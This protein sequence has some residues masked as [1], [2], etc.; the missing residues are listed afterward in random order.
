MSELNPNHPV[1]VETR[2]QWHKLAAILM[3]KM[4]RV[5]VEIFP[6]DVE[7]LGNNQKGIVIDCRGGKFV[8]RL[9]PMQ[10]G[11]RL[12]REEGGLPV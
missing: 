12:A 7:N 10:E 11:E 9:V 3:Q 2:D 4:G 5:E 1:V 6:R 8:L